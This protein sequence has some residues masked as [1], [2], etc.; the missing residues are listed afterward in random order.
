VDDNVVAQEEMSPI[1]KP[2]VHGCEFFIIDIITPFG[3]IKCL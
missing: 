3:I 2:T 1:G